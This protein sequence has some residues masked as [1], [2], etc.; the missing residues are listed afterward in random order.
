MVPAERC[1]LNVMDVALE[2]A[3]ETLEIQD[4]QRLA[5]AAREALINAVKVMEEQAVGD[6]LEMEITVS[7]DEDWIA[8]Q[9]VDTGPGLPQDW[10]HNLTGRRSDE[11]VVQQSGRGLMFIRR[12]VDELQSEMDDKG[13]H[14]LTMRK[15]RSGN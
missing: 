3:L 7:A 15:R 10:Q 13:R 6:N 2:A 1:W 11:S 5:F 9:V 4:R 14:I 12:F 8:V